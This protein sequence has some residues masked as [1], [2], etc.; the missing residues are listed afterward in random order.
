MIILYKYMS[1][2]IKYTD[3]LTY[4]SPQTNKSNLFLQ[5]KDNS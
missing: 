3:S 2:D 1:I 4:Y 5:F